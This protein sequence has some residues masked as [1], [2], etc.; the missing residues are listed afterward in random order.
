MNVKESIKEVVEKNRG[1]LTDEEVQKQIEVFE[2][3]FIEGETPAEAMNLSSDYLNQVYAYG[4]ALYQKRKITEARAL[5]YWLNKMNFSQPKF[6][7]ALIECDLQL[8]DWQS[9]INYLMQIAFIYPEDPAPYEKICDCL[10]ELN[11]LPGA[12][13]MLEKAIARGKKDPQHS[14]SVEKWKMQ[15]EYILDQLDIDPKLIEEA[16]AEIAAKEKIN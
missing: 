7:L 6:I 9:A 5:F 14:K 16:R 1:D 13:V 15:Y 2:K 3:V 4:Y 12:L 8:K 11:D 10:M